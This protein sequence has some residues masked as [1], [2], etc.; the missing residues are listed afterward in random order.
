MSDKAQAERLKILPQWWQLWRNPIFHRYRRSRLRVSSLITGAL[1][2]GGTSLLFYLMALGVTVTQT[3]LPFEETAVYPFGLLVLLQIFILNFVGTGE[4]AAGMAR[5]SVDEVLTYQRLTPLSPATKIIGYLVGLPVR[6]FYHFILTVPVTVII[7]T[8]GQI[9]AEIWLP[10]YA[11]L[12]TSTLMFYLLAMSVGFIMGKRF[13]ALISQGLVAL[14][15]FALPQLSNFG[16]VIFEYLTIRPALFAAANKMLPKVKMFEHDQYALFYHWE[17]SHT[18]YCIVL[19]CLIAW[20]FYSL[21]LRRWRRESSHLLSK[22]QSVAIVSILHIITLG[23]VWANTSNGSIFDVQIQT[24]NPEMALI[25][26]T[27]SENVELIA[28]SVLAL[29]GIIGFSFAILLQYIYTPD[30]FRYIA[31]LR[32]RKNQDKTPYAVLSDSASGIPT[33]LLITLITTVAW[34]IYSNHLSQ[35]PRIAEFIAGESWLPIDTM[36]IAVSVTTLLSHGLSLEYLGKKLNGTIACFTWVTPLA[37]ALLLSAWSFGEKASS[38]IYGFS[39]L[40]M[41]F[42]PGYLIVGLHNSEDPT[43]FIYGCQVGLF[44]YFSIG[45]YCLIRIIQRHKRFMLMRESNSFLAKN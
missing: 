27:I 24:R 21:M 8:T 40:S 4:V 19:Q 35:S 33:S 20:I 42:S 37:V 32:E 28:A 43:L 9:P 14:L 41:H 13:S 22:V 39:P 44:V 6:Q 3:E 11:V 25:Q 17:V 31:G 38:F 12:F 16:F 30:K 29:Y 1:L 7:I 18:I 15:Y 10:I 45:L 26:Q 34:L 23:G 2:Y 5:E 36:L